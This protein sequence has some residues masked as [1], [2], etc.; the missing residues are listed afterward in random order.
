MKKIFSLTLSLLLLASCSNASEENS[1]SVENLNSDNQTNFET[2]SGETVFW[3]GQ[4][5][6][7]GPISINLFDLDSGTSVFAK[8]INLDDSIGPSNTGSYGSNY[9]VQYNPNTED[10]FFFT[11]GQSMGMGDEC[12]NKDETC[13]DRIY[14]LAKSSD[15]PELIY[16][17]DGLINNWIVNP[18]DNSILLTQN[19]KDEGASFTKIDTESADV[20]FSISNEYSDQRSFSEMK[21]SPDGEHTLQ[22]SISYSA[23][24]LNIV[25]TNKFDNST[26]A[27]EEIRHGGSTYVYAMTNISPN[28]KYFVQYEG[29]GQKRLYL[30]EIGKNSNMIEFEG[31]IEN[32][33]IYWSGDSEK[34]MI[35]STE[36]ALYY[37]I[38]TQEFVKVAESENPLALA[39]APSVENIVFA[40]DLLEVFNI[41]SGEF[42]EIS[43]PNDSGLDR[44]KGVQIFNKL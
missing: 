28:E 23:D 11:R 30:S 44:I 12:V 31:S 3:A 22:T 17:L 41:N 16:D 25:F 20:L 36:G 24:E 8:E 2:Q 9:A 39:W 18:F 4:T 10:F 42:T 14:K 6:F 21:L 32:Y 26:G 7:N 5:E 27:K 29:K 19:T 15:T 13:N 1:V 35:F 37:D 33:N 40:S 43:E 38:N 34:F